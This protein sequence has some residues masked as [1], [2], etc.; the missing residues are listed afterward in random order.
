MGWM[1]NKRKR[2]HG[3]QGKRNLLGTQTWKDNSHMISHICLL[4]P[5]V[6]KCGQEYICLFYLE[7]NSLERGKAHLLIFVSSLSSTQ[8]Y[9]NIPSLKYVYLSHHNY[10]HL[11]EKLRKRSRLFYKW[12][13]RMYTVCHHHD[14]RR[15]LCLGKLER[16]NISPYMYL[17]LNI[18]NI[19]SAFIRQI[20]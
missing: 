17:Y 12:L 10:R 5:R 11:E 2:S 7:L 4:H 16:T 19:R 9:L 8:P 1:W 13:L 3:C 15:Y 6:S 20:T 18:F 14:D